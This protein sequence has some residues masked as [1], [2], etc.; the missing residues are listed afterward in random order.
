MIGHLLRLREL[1]DKRGGFTAFIP[2]SYQPGNTD[3][4]GETATGV[5]YL[6]VLATSRL[7]LDNFD[8]LQASWVT[9]GAKMGQVALFFGAN[10]MGSTMLEENVVAATGISHAMTPDEIVRLIGD[11][12]FHPAQRN[13]VYEILK[14]Y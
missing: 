9:Q 12:G 3:L 2:W 4:A 13:N 6:R 7:L 1:Q 10:D 5:E 11:A 8:N 14:E